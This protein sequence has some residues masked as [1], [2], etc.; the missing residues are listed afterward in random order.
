MGATGDARWDDA[1]PRASPSAV[2]AS[3][4]TDSSA[5]DSSATASAK[6]LPRTDAWWR[7]PSLWLTVVVALYIL[8]MSAAQ[9]AQPL[10]RDEGAF[11]TIAQEILHGGLP[12]R[13]A[14]DHKGP[15]IYYLL[16]TL[17]AL[18]QPLGLMG[19]IIVVRLGVV[20]ANVLT[21]FG[22]LL[23]G[24]RWWRPGVGVLAALL[25]LVALPLYEGY[26]A[27][28]EPFAVVCLVWAVVV[29]GQ[30]SSRPPAVT[31]LLAGVLV[32]VSSVF[33]QSTIVGVAG[34]A[35]V[36]VAAVGSRWTGRWLVLRGVVQTALVGIGAALPWLVIC[37]VFALFGGLDALVGD[38]VFAN[39]ADPPFTVAAIWSAM[40]TEFSALPLLWAAPVLVIAGALAR[41]LWVR[42]R[43][44]LP[45]AGAW[46][47]V[48][49][50]AL[51]F[52]PFL[53]HARPHYWLPIIPWAAL[54][55]AAGAIAL[56]NAL[57]SATRVRASDAGWS[58]W[59]AAMALPALLAV[60]FVASAGQLA[61][62]RPLVTAGPTLGTQVAAGDWIAQHTTS[63][64]RVL[65]APAEPEYYFLSGRLPA[66]SFVYLLPVNASPRLLNV[67]AEQTR[68]GQFDA[69][70]WESW[71][72]G[73]TWSAI[74]AALRQRYTLAARSPATG[75]Q[76]YLPAA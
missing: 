35:V 69:V 41:W 66:T 22:I 18:G 25:W 13:D 70:V 61:L 72:D 38:V 3:G 11:L 16:A 9:V 27:L 23:I 63:D 49:I 74:D 75:L 36:A 15:G 40:F 58:A 34:V 7:S 67:V 46:A 56:A 57:W 30:P 19:Q 2:T 24:R 51:N 60:L 33:Q 14:F 26:F 1:A 73:P 32:G 71:S 54:L 50:G 12:Y 37:A 59:P 48:L 52:A 20:A 42:R 17:L 64:A 39:F 53:T 29:A 44:A 31:A 68:S 6:A 8:A 65:V 5:T 10:S 76:L 55:A 28:T 45:N 21:A 62:S 47:V 43:T 4:A